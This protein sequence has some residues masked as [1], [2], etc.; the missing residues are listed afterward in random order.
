MACDDAGP[1]CNFEY[2]IKFSRNQALREPASVRLKDQRN[3][4]FLVEPGD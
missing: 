2:P 4:I 1:G 3:E